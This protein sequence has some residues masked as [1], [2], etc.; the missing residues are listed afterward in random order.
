MVLQAFEIPYGIGPDAHVQ[1]RRAHNRKTLSRVAGQKHSEAMQ[2][3]WAAD[4]RGPARMR[5]ST[6]VF[7]RGA[8]LG[9]RALGA[10]LEPGP[11]FGGSGFGSQLLVLDRRLVAG[12]RDRQLA[13]A[14]AQKAVVR[15]VS[16]LLGRHAVELAEAYN[17]MALDD[18]VDGHYRPPVQYGWRGCA[19]LTTYGS[20]RGRQKCPPAAGQGSLVLRGAEGGGAGAGR[21]R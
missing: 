6:S 21:L 14:L 13:A 1:L 3:G 19:Q 2:S 10:A 12:K 7:I 5:Y 16:D 17:G 4:E 11:A 18:G 20:P 15:A 9:T 8:L